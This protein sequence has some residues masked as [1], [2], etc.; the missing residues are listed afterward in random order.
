MTTY[1][2]NEQIK[3]LTKEKFINNGYTYIYNLLLSSDE[4]K[5]E[6]AHHAA[7]VVHFSNVTLHFRSS[8]SL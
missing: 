2:D 1:T 8:A 3:A 5:R 7:I 6:R 4:E